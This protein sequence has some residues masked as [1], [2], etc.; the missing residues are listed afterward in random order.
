M[1]RA[2]VLGGGVAGLVAA[3][4]LRDRGHDVTLL[5][6]R[7]WLGGRAFSSPDPVTGHVLDNGGH[8]MLGC[9]VAMRRLVRRI[10]SENGFDAHRSLTMAY[11]TR[12]GRAARLALSRL[13]VPFAMPFALARLPITVRERFAALRGMAAVLRRAPDEQSFGEWLRRHGQLGAPDAWFWRPLCR[14]VMNVEPDDAAA[15]DFLATL[16]EAFAGSAARAAFHVPKRPWGELLGAPAMRALTAAGVVVRTGVRATG[17]RITNGA[18]AAI[19]TSTGDSVA[20]GSGDLVVSALPWFALHALAP[21]VAPALHTLR[22]SP[23]TS[24]FVTS[25]NDVP[26]LPDEGPVVA[27]VDGD[28]FH[29]VLRTPGGDPR[30][31]SLLS[32]GNRVFDGMSVD[33]MV[34]LARSQLAAC[35]P[36]WSGRDGAVIRIRREQHATFVA[37]P[38]ARALRPRPGRSAR[39]ANL[40]L[41][42]DWTDVGLPATLEGAARSGEAMLAAL[43]RGE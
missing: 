21:D 2:V 25:A 23:I 7:R 39:I 33:A 36:N 22:S 12:D 19:E 3:F 30:C 18:I 41:C 31:F 5:E 6:S 38:G 29:F 15:N 13:P 27:L 34:A 20:I 11:R 24:A 32:G 10:G 35:Y 4:G 28:P 17:L 37:A 43:A 1:T 16:R 9:Y 42:G 40:R 8:V 14:A 26:P